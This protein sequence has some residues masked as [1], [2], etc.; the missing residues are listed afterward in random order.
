[1]DKEEVRRTAIYYPI[2]GRIVTDADYENVIIKYYGG[3]LLD[4]YSYNLDHDQEVILLKD[5]NFLAA[6]K[7][8]ISQ[9]VDL[10]RGAG[11]NVEYIEKAKTDG[12]PIDCAFKLT[13][14]DY[15]EGILTSVTEYLN[16]KRYKFMRGSEDTVLTTIT[17]A[18][19]LSSYFG[20]EFYPDDTNSTTLTKSDFIQNFNIGVS[21]YAS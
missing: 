8:E 9:M 5:D 20:K 21:A 3:V 11:I 19:E 18:I 4:V 14:D 15:Y 13:S 12:L 7:T 10:K 1:M 2:D 6:H 16:T 17:L